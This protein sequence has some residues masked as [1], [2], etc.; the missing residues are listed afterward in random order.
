MN[1]LAFLHRDRVA[2]GDGDL[3]LV[4][5][6]EAVARGHGIV[7]G[8]QLEPLAGDDRDLLVDVVDRPV[9]DHGLRVALHRDMALG[10]DPVDFGIAAIGV[11]V[12]GSR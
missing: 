6:F 5:P 12:F 7:C 10:L 2:A 1:R 9:A 11:A 4:V 3:L 8:G